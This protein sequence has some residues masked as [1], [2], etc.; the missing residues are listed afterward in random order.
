M[1]SNYEQI[2]KLHQQNQPG[3]MQANLVSDEAKFQVFQAV[4]DELFRSFDGQVKVRDFN[5]ISACIF[6]WIEENCKPTNLRSVTMSILSQVK[7]EHQLQQLKQES[8]ALGLH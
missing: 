6:G 7:K 8:A 5:E 4:C 3:A 2:V 1:K